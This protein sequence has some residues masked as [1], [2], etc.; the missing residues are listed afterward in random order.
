MHSVITFPVLQRSSTQQSL[1]CMAG[2][3]SN[4]EQECKFI[5]TVQHPN[6]V[7]KFGIHYNDTVSLA[8]RQSCSWKCY[9]LNL[10]LLDVIVGGAPTIGFI[11][12]P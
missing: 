5:C 10:E 2:L 6:I 12:S 8:N 3:Y 4:F 7:Q 9:M 11:L 1:P